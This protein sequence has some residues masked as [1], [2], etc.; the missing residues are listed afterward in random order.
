MKL[1]HKFVVNFPEKLEEKTIY[2]SIEYSIV[3]HKCC[4]GCGHDVITPISPID[5]TLI[6]NGESIT[7]D[8]SIGNW[9]LPCKSHYWIK[10]NKVV[11]AKSWS[12]KEINEIR[13]QE[14]TEKQV[15]FESKKNS[16][17]QF[18]ETNPKST[19]VDYSKSNILMTL[20][21]FFKR[22]RNK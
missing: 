2:I 12:V 11:W 3:G 17:K 16:Y 18:N 10:Q 7:L 13:K 20:I 4:C 6:Y 5:W 19:E 21:K 9:G 1:N 8:P 14:N 15:F 22:F